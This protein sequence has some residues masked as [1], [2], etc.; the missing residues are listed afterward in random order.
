MCRDVTKSFP[1]TERGPGAIDCF[2]FHGQKIWVGRS[3]SFFFFFFV[4]TFVELPKEHF[5]AVQEFSKTGF[6]QKLQKYFYNCL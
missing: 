1:K 6:L 5:Q 2:R 4:D 3:A